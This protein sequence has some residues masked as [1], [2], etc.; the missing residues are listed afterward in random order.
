MTWHDIT[1]CSSTIG[2]FLTGTLVPIEGVKWIDLLNKCLVCKSSVTS[3]PTTN[4]LRTS[5]K[6][7]TCTV[8]KLIQRNPFKHRIGCPENAS[9][10]KLRGIELSYSLDPSLI[11]A[12]W[13]KCTQFCS[14]CTQTHKNNSIVHLHKEIEICSSKKFKESL[15]SREIQWALF[16]NISSPQHTLYQVKFLMAVWT[17]ELLL[18]VET[19]YVW[20]D[21]S[22]KF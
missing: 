10:K 18:M 2:L 12:S 21:R 3:Q 15:L 4:I 7:Q 22:N 9:F 19:W 14:Q 11:R 8:A 17:S 1:G 13:N 6:F 20:D 16:Q 5:P